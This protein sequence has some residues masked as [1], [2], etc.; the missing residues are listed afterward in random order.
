MVRKYENSGPGWA[1]VAYAIEGFQKEW[2]RHVELRLV[3]QVH[4]RRA[5]GR[6]VASVWTTRAPHAPFATSPQRYEAEV[7]SWSQGTLPSQF[8][9][10]LTLLGAALEDEKQVAI[11]ESFF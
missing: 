11:Q 2:G 8:I 7:Y 1:D 9:R 3:G 5:T 6:L 10:L 4:G